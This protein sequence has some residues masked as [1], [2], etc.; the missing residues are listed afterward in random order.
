MGRRCQVL[1]AITY[2]KSTAWSAFARTIDAIFAGYQECRTL[3]SAASRELIEILFDVGGIDR[4]VIAWSQRDGAVGPQVLIQRP[5][6]HIER[7]R[8]EAGLRNLVRQHEV[9]GKFQFHNVRQPIGIRT[10]VEEFDAWGE[11]FSCP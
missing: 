7:P 5:R 10:T 9:L 1:S 2:R 3:T 8:H 4:T 11:V 6:R